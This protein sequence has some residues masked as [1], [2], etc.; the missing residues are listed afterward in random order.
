MPKLY[1]CLR[2]RPSQAQALVLLRM[3]TIVF[4][5]IFAELLHSCTVTSQL[6][7]NPPFLAIL[8]F[9]D[10]QTPPIW[11]PLWNFPKTNKRARNFLPITVPIPT[12]KTFIVDINAFYAF[13][14]NPS[15]EYASIT[16]LQFSC[17][18]CL[19]LLSSSLKLTIIEK[20]FQKEIM[21]SHDV[22]ATWFI[23]VPNSELL[24]A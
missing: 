14:S 4:G 5:K 3:V 24:P 23:L 8:T 7:L 10:S 11:N 17:I 16:R 15:R 13:L 6:F 1:H 20:L 21:M 2:R 22:V 18:I 12:P 9:T 19:V